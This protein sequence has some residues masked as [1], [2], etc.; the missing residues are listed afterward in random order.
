M[1]CLTFNAANF[2]MSYGALTGAVGTGSPVPANTGTLLTA[3]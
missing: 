2:I 3:E 1:R